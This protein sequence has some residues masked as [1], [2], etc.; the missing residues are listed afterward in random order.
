MKLSVLVLLVFFVL[1]LMIRSS[2]C[3]DEGT[4][5]YLAVV[6]A[7]NV[8]KQAYA[9]VLDAEMAGAN[10]SSL[11]ARLN[12]AGGFLA[13]ADMAYRN[14]DYVRAS[15]KAKECVTKANGVFADASGLRV[16]ALVDARRRFLNMLMLSITSAVVFVVGLVLVW[17]WFRRSY[18]RRLLKMK[19]EVVS[20]V[21][22]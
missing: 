22:A 5:A 12:E 10:V 4:E 2:S 16:S 14:K 11:I 21:G 18:L 3:I 15:G 9:V 8:L 6:E 13:E 20:D 17:I 19:P 1:C 7:D